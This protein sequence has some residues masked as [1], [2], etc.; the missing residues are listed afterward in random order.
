MSL[1]PGLGDSL[2]K[3]MAAHST[4]LAWEVPWTE[5][6]GGPQSMG[7]QCIE[8]SLVTNTFTLRIIWFK[9]TIAARLQNPA[10]AVSPTHSQIPQ[11]GQ[12]ADGFSIPNPE[13]NT[14]HFYGQHSC[15][16]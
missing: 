9:M 2:E 13:N 14:H 5:E 10:I 7:S 15:H 11:H 12:K 4:I 16:K 8:H 1:I 3:K 6:P